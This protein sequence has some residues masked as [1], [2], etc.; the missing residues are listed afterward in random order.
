MTDYEVSSHYTSKHISSVVRHVT[1]LAL[2]FSTA[3]WLYMKIDDMTIPQK[4]SQE[5]WSPWA[6]W[7]YGSW[8]Y[9]LHVSRW[10]QTNMWNH[11]SDHFA[12]RWFLSFWVCSSVSGKLRFTPSKQAV[13]ILSESNEKRLLLPC[14]V[15]MYEVWKI[16]KP[17]ILQT[18]PLVL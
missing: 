5:S 18:F 8:T 12:K 14:P 16:V 7:L 10:A 6:G 15:Y 13:N 4:R 11:T 3:Q 17:Q 1:I 2:A 9:L